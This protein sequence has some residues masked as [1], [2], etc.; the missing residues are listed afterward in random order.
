MSWPASLNFDAGGG[1]KEVWDLLA[2]FAATASNW[3]PPSIPLRFG[4]WGLSR[5][6]SW[7]YLLSHEIGPS[8]CSSH[9]GRIPYNISDD[10]SLLL[11]YC[12]WS[13][14]LMVLY[15][16]SIFVPNIIYWLNIT[17]DYRICCCFIFLNNVNYF[18]E[19]NSQLA[20]FLE[21]W[22][23]LIADYSVK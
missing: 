11:V 23:I 14:R 17:F 18:I 21:T 7:R 9:C 6:G 1:K 8:A 13:Q 12:D 19:Q 15:F 2:K 16:H 10:T 22:Q 5:S 4:P 3:A 20:R